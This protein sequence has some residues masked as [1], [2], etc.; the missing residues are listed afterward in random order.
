MNIHNQ[1][2][3]VTLINK[4]TMITSG[5][6]VVITDLSHGPS[7]YFMKICAVGA[8][9]KLCNFMNMPKTKLLMPVSNVPIAAVTRNV[10]RLFSSQSYR[11]S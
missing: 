10:R 8:M 4:V 7:I 3:F 1:R 6:K 5:N 2:A 9:T 11:V